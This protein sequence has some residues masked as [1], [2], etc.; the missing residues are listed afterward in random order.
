MSRHCYL[1]L[2]ISLSFSCASARA[3]EPDILDT[4]AKRP[5]SVQVKN[6]SGA[7]T[8]ARFGDPKLAEAVDDLGFAPKPWTVPSLIKQYRDLKGKD[9][10]ACAHLLRVLAASR[11]ARAASVLGPA[12]TDQSLAIRVAATYGIMDYFMNQPVNGGTEQH[13]EAARKWWQ[14]HERDRSTSAPKLHALSPGDNSVELLAATPNL[15]HATKS[16]NERALQF[17]KTHRELIGAFV[18]VVT[19]SRLPKAEQPRRIPEVYQRLRPALVNAKVT[20]IPNTQASRIWGER[21]KYTA[22]ELADKLVEAQA[23]GNF[24]C[25]GEQTCDTLLKDN[26]AALSDLVLADLKSSDTTRQQRGLNTIRDLGVPR[27]NQ[28]VRQILVSKPDLQ[29]EAAYAL[30]GLNDYQ[31]ISLLVARDG[32]DPMKFFEV[33]RLLSRDRPADAAIIKQL[34]AIDPQIRW[35]AAYALAESGNSNLMPQVRRLVK[36]KD[37]RVRKWAGSIPYFF[38]DKEYVAAREVI[39]PL[40]QDEDREVR[41][42]VA[43]LLACKK[44]AACAACLL[45]LV[46]DES[47]D[48]SAHSNIVHAIE[49]LTGSSFGFYTGSDAWKPT[50][51]NNR[52][53]IEA[54][55]AWIAKHAQ[56]HR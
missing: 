37:A 2:A 14:Q 53:A 52:A 18:S 10:K 28:E 31:A 1:I 48:E 38:K 41:A 47:L 9:E 20:V 46:K 35:R 55:E 29:T 40:L 16:A 56:N 30:R 25:F 22:D 8:T 54:Y 6:Q 17:R 26:L 21:N 11:D 19:I 49:N 42:Y 4:A 15:P 34:S 51:A 7:W 5:L 50:T 13:M 33:L 32:K 3:K 23:F 39:L 45:T 12:L 27:C 24:Y 36:D 43:G 44:D